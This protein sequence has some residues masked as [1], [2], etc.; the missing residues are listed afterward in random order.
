MP[1]I[2]CQWSVVRKADYVRY[3]LLDGVAIRRSPFA[4]NSRHSPFAICNSPDQE[5]AN[6]FPSYGATSSGEKRRAN[7]EGRLRPCLP[8]LARTRYDGGSL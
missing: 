8:P 3:Q 2:G 6:D 5:K 1:V 7:S 4:L